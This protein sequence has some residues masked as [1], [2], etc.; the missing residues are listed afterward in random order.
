MEPQYHKINLI[1][2][3]RRQ[4]RGRQPGK[5]IC[6]PHKTPKQ[7]SLSI[8]RCG[9]RLIPKQ[10][11]VFSQLQILL[12]PLLIFLSHFSIIIMFS[13]SWFYF[14]D[15]SS[16]ADSSSG[17]CV[18]F[19][20]VRYSFCWFLRQ[21]LL[22]SMPVLISQGLS[23]PPFPVEASLCWLTFP[24]ALKDWRGHCQSHCFGQQLQRAPHTTS[25]ALSLG[26]SVFLSSWP[27][28]QLFLQML[29]TELD[30]GRACKQSQAPQP[31]LGLS[32]A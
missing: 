30:Q 27:E 4:T 5:Y 23:S 32:L 3:K 28:G 2:S 17:K 29:L 18:S 1:C 6:T 25:Q 24:R 22:P 20:Y 7:K 11:T 10:Q 8:L 9:K 16:S 15:A 12:V 31:Q 14:S 26:E 13:L 19:L 21:R